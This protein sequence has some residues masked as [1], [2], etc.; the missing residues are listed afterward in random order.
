MHGFLWCRVKSARVKENL[1]IGWCFSTMLLVRFRDY[2]SF[3]FC[4]FFFYI[5]SHT[6]LREEGPIVARATKFRAIKDLFVR[7][8][9]LWSFSESCIAGVH[10][11]VDTSAGEYT[12]FEGVGKETRKS[13]SELTRRDDTPASLLFMRQTLAVKRYGRR[14]ARK[15]GVRE[16]ERGGWGI[17][18][19]PRNSM[20]ERASRR[21][22]STPEESPPETLRER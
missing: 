17:R 15:R 8:I 19:N 13:M 22:W 2:T 21:D 14:L 18:T 7:W 11:L 5:I 6:K 1:L 20:R 4:F 16:R 12:S 9:C 3:L 10:S